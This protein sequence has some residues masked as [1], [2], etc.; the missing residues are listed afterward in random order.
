[1]LHPARTLAHH[2]RLFPA[3]REGRGGSAVGR[4]IYA[5]ESSI[6]KQQTGR[7]W[8]HFLK[9]AFCATLFN[10]LS[11]CSLWSL[12]IRTKAVLFFTHSNAFSHHDD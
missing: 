7:H 4:G 3:H 8:G 5:L 9:A 6:E 2:A 10:K 11:L 12:F 1:M